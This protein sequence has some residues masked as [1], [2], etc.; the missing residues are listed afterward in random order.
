MLFTKHYQDVQRIK[1]IPVKGK[2]KKF[3]LV[4]KSVYSYLWSWVES[5]GKVFPSLSR[6]GNDLGTPKRTI[7]RAI[8]TLV[9]MGIVT[10]H[11]RRDTSNEYEVISPAQVVKLSNTKVDAELPAKDSFGIF[12]KESIDMVMR[13]LSNMIP[14]KV[15]RHYSFATIK[16]QEATDVIDCDSPTTPITYKSNDDIEHPVRSNNLMEVN[17]NQTIS[18]EGGGE[19]VPKYDGEHVHKGPAKKPEWDPDGW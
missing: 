6:I 7:Q 11:Q 19:V 10:K 2:M 1:T 12:S 5:S 3:T 13:T 14:L 18:A 16:P 8:D 9:E 4:D 17:W 15:R